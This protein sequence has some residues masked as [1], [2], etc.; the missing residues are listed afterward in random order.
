MFSYVNWY[1]PCTT[2]SCKVQKRMNQSLLASD[3]LIDQDNII[4]INFLELSLLF[5]IFFSMSYLTNKIFR[6]SHIVVRKQTNVNDL[7]NNV[8]WDWK[9]SKACQDH[10]TLLYYLQ[11]LQFM[12]FICTVNWIEIS[13]PKIFL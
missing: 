13:R 11:M 9:S 2:K 1:A 10:N 6:P 7:P 5:V 8:F 3:K 4:W 12:H